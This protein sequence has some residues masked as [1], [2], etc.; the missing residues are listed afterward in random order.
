MRRPHFPNTPSRQVLTIG[1]VF[2]VAGTIVVS[3]GVGQLQRARSDLDRLDNRLLPATIELASADHDFTQSTRALLTV[4]AT[5][6]GATDVLALARVTDLRT[7]AIRHWRAFKIHADDVPKTSLLVHA[8]ES[9]I[10]VLEATAA[11]LIRSV[12]DSD[13]LKYQGFASALDRDLGVL[14]ERFRSSLR[15]A[16]STAR[17][18]TDTTLWTA[19][20]AYAVAFVV[21]GAI[22]LIAVKRSRRGEVETA[23][24][25]AE[26]AR[27]T[28]RDQLAARVQRGLEMTRDEEESFEVIDG[29]LRASF[30]ASPV[31][32]LVA[33]SSRGH[34]RRVAGTTDGAA[35][36]STCAVTSPGDCPATRQNQT[37]EF[38]RSDALDACPFLRHRA[39]EVCSATCVPVGVMGKSKGVVCAI[40]VAGSPVDADGLA[41]LELMARKTGERMTMLR[42]FARTHT[43]ASTDPL[44]SLANRRSLEEAARSL[45]DGRRPYVVAY[46]D[47]DHFKR[48]N[49]E[50]GHDAGDKALRVFA[51]VLRDSVRPGDFPARYGGE[52]FVVILPDCSVGDA[53][54][55]LD[56]V[57]SA[58]REALAATA[59]P[60]FT[61]S[62]G[63]SSPDSMRPFEDVVTE[64]DGWLR[65]AKTTGRDR[66]VGPRPELAAA[67]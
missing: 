44:T 65:V 33:D 66:V 54:R 45:T 64:A 5:P 40:G 18:A 8:A 36:G 50:H 42:S 43:Q 59:L 46:G 61:V 4:L 30:G 24:T 37:M 63:L 41:R 55:V 3:L 7:S 60:E 15:R 53:T 16:S 21:I 27:H 1:L 67:V 17:H 2:I 6:G 9:Q 19:L 13:L 58:L 11:A 56:R 22:T 12:T 10:A 57:R 49:D 39:G 28:D 52:E 23:R 48:L 20:T 32:L 35:I 38:G 47:L 62:F 34:L 29:A 31:E 25:D 26:R 14:I 51:R